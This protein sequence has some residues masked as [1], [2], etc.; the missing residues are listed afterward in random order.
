[1]LLGDNVLFRLAEHIFVGVTVGYAVVVVF[2]NVLAPK[3]LL[4]VVQ[5]LSQGDWD[6]LLLL[7]ISLLLGLL[8]LTKPLRR[9]SWLGTLSVAFL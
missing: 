8:L 2:H 3:L 1:Y 7:G 5:A 4:P 9:L 6:Q